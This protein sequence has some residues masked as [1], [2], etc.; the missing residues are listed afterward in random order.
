MG[1][2]GLACIATAISKLKGNAWIKTRVITHDISLWE[3]K[4]SF[5]NNYKIICPDITAILQTTIYNMTNIL[6]PN[7]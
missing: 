3:V 5:R 6:I 1:V 7:V 2:G 4:S